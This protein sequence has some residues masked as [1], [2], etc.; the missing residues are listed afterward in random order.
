MTRTSILVALRRL[1]T[2]CLLLLGAPALAGTIL[3]G[4]YVLLDHG[5][6]NLG[7]DYG[8][9]VDGIGELFSV[10]LGGAQTLLTWGGG[11]TASLSGTLYDNDT[12]D[13]W[14]V[15]YDLTGVT[16][17][18]TQGFHATAG[19]GTLTDPLS[20][21]TNL[22][23]RTN[24]NGYVFTFL[25]DGHRI[26]GDNDTPVG[27][28]WLEPPS[29]TDDWIVRAAPIPEPGTATLLTLGLLALGVA[30]RP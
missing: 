27:R 13:I 8:L 24:N 2:V 18:G 19:T 29:S 4:T 23:G 22:V 17:V 16:A 10:E 12:G 11:A 20:N 30:R 3:P 9:R 25:A 14:T 28:G 7:P 26:S 5:D 1:A 6:G 21:V 15:S